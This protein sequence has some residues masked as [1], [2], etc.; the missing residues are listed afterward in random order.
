VPTILR[1]GPYR[2]YFYSHEPDEPAR[3]HLDRDDESA[4][5]WLMPVRLARNRGFSAVELGRIQP[6]LE[7]NESLLQE[8][9]RETPFESCLL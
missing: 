2:V 3:V 4:K 6:I 7:E 8:K 5:F 1:S 9:W